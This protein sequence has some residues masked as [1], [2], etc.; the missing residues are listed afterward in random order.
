MNEQPSQSIASPGPSASRVRKWRRHLRRLWWRWSERW[1]L[2]ELAMFFRALPLLLLWLIIPI[3]LLA[4][5]SCW[6]VRATQKHELAARSY[7]Q[8]TMTISHSEDGPLVL[9]VAQPTRLFLEGPEA[10][11]APLAVWLVRATPAL[12]TPTSASSYVVAFGSPKGI[13][14]TDEEGNPA[15]PEIVLTPAP[16]P[17]TPALLYLRPASPPGDPLP[18]KTQLE[19]QVRGPTGVLNPT[20]MTITLG[21]ESTW[22]SG[23]RRWLGLV[24]G[25]TTTLIIALATAMVGFGVQQWRKLE[26]ERASRKEEHNKAINEIA[27]LQQ[28]LKRN[29]SQ[30][31]RQYLKLRGRSAPPWNQARIRGHLQEVWEKNAPVELQ[32]VIDLIRAPK[33]VDLLLT[34]AGRIG[35]DKTAAALEWAYR[36]L[37]EGWQLKIRDTIWTLREHDE[38][39]ARLTGAVFQEIQDK[40]WHAILRPW[41][42]LAFW[43]DDPLPLEPQVEAGLQFLGLEVNPFGSA[44]AEVD[45]LLLACY[46]ASEALPPTGPGLVIGAARA[47]K[48][49]MALSLAHDSLRAHQRFPVYCPARPEL[50][51]WH[52]QLQQVGQALSKTLLYYLAVKPQEFLERDIAGRTA[53]AH[54]LKRYANGDN[55]TVALHQAGLPQIGDGR[56]MLE[57]IE[58]LT[59][60]L[61]FTTPLTGDDLLILVSEARPHNFQRTLILMDVQQVGGDQPEEGDRYVQSLLELM[62]RLTRVGIVVRIF[63]PDVLWESWQK[64]EDWPLPPHMRLKWTDEDLR[65]LLQRRLNQAGEDDLATWCDKGATSVIPW[66]NERLIQASPTPRNLIEKGNAL[67]RRIGQ[68]RRPLSRKDLEDIL[69]PPPDS[70]RGENEHPD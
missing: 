43:R 28:E 36:T 52:D 69:G 40:P 5:S 3:L 44:Q 65:Q 22:E 11:A 29:L 9:E 35:P 61:S 39:K 26:E 70:T 53:M 7:A 41:P 1:P 51:Q 67:L 24:T 2:T 42:H 25:T 31:A 60:G 16:V 15:R 38:Y 54:L 21:L 68:K 13:A 59:Q 50:G 34:T 27:G 62:D 14:F 4:L 37:D 48:T 20:P 56:R 17:G 63:L 8:A 57:E 58:Q 32:T 18:T 30:G 23:W 49:A 19:V 6:Q 47:G 55:L 45:H 33:N 66:P 46:V 64:P 10:R 12:S